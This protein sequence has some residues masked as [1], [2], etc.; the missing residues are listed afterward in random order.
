M[1]GKTLWAITVSSGNR[2]EAQPLED[3]LQ[4]TAQYLHMQ[5]GGL[6]FGTGSR[7]NDIQADAAALQQAKHFFLSANQ[8]DVT[9][10]AAE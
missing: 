2:S 4:R 5:W 8:P 9:D 10:P 1:R 6:L 3:A 7:P